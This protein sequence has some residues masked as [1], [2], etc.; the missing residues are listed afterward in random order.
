[1]SGTRKPATAAK[2]EIQRIAVDPRG[3]DSTG[4]YWGAGPDV[5]IATTADG[6]DEVTVRAKSVADARTKAAA[7]LARQPGQPRTKEPLGGKAPRTTRHEIDWTHPS[8]GAVVRLR[9]TH[10]RDYLVEGTDHVEVESIRPRRAALPITETGYSSSFIDWRQLQ[11]AGGPVAFIEG[12]LARE[13]QSKDWK[14]RDLAERQGDLFKW[15]DAQA[16]VGTKR[17]KP[18]TPA[19]VPRKRRD[20]GGSEPA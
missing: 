17:R 13:T 12:W 19:S 8:T 2:L 7:E 6:S 16:E 18:R 1:M 5:F 15:A 4:A 3:Y 9:I 20:R 11:A 14:K 10:A